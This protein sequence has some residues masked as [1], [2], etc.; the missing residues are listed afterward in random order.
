ML[1]LESLSMSST[2]NTFLAAQLKAP[3][4]R[5]F[6]TDLVAD[7]HMNIFQV[8]PSSSAS[9]TRLFCIPHA[10]GGPSSFRGWSKDLSP[11]IEVSV[12]Q[13]PGRERRYREPCY[14]NIELLVSDL[15]EAI[16]P[17]I[18]ERQ[19]FAFFGNSLGGLIAF[20]V[21]HQIRSR[22]DLEATHL[23]VSASGPPHI[24]SLLPNI[25]HLKER[26]FIRKISER[27]GGISESILMDPSLL[28]AILPALRADFT[29]LEHYVRKQPRPLSCPITAFGGRFDRSLL[30]Q[31]LELWK[32]QT[33]GVF[34]SIFL[35]ECHLFVQSAREILIECIRETL[36][37]ADQV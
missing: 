10:G 26:D 15:T 20:E 29:M 35:Y 1:T 13:L 30:P 16:L 8:P 32:D 23:F 3:E 22:S 14:S 37:A 33:H 9:V 31:T 34:K 21:L 27:Y 18:A 25:A 4:P 7:R 5:L 17:F 2:G 12:V 24:P 19:K 6:T 36:L 11:E 28:S